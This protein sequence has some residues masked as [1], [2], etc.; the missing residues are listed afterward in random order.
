MK[1]NENDAAEA[2]KIFFGERLQSGNYSKTQELLWIRL[3]RTGE[4][5][6][7]Y[8]SIVGKHFVEMF[9]PFS[10]SWID[11]RMRHGPWISRNGKWQNQNQNENDNKNPNKQP[12]KNRAIK[13]FSA[14]FPGKSVSLRRFNGKLWSSGESPT[15][16]VESMSTD[17]TKSKFVYDGIWRVL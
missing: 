17:Q 6:C 15:R 2:F 8:F 16:Q 13:S 4:S 10:F 5:I 11:K 12:A 7:K 3:V 9:F 14:R 1:M